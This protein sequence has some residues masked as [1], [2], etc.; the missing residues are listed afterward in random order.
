M[1]VKILKRSGGTLAYYPKLEKVQRKLWRV[2]TQPAAE[3][4]AGKEDED[5]R[6][7]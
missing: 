6:E 7:S 2:R 5:R 4:N 3:W 1:K